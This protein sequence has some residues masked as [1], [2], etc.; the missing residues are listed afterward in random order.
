M[1]NTELIDETQLVASMADV[2]FEMAMQWHLFKNGKLKIPEA[3]VHIGFAS[4][5]VNA[6]RNEVVNNHFLGITRQ[7]DFIGTLERTKKENRSLKNE[8]ISV[9]NKKAK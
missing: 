5:I 3:K 4:Q 2:R 1:S 6:Y 7:I 8:L 9:G